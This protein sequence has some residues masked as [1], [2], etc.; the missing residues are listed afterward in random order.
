MN[1]VDLRLKLRHFFKKNGKIII[2]ILIIW[3]SIFFIN[4]ILKNRPVNLTPETT[5]EMH[6]SV[7]DVST[8][9]PSSLRKPIEDVIDEYVGYCNEGNY[10]KA[11]DMLSDDCKEYEFNNNVE[12]FMSHVISKMPVP[13]KYSIQDY[14]NFKC[15]NKT[16][17]VYQIKYIDDLLATGLTN[18]QYAYTSEKLTFYRDNNKLKM[19]AGDYMYHTDI[20]NISENEYLK[21]DIIDKL[22][23]YSTETYKVKIT[24]RSNY[25]VV[26]SDQQEVDEVILTLPNETRK[27]LE[28]DDI[29]LNPQQTIEV[30]FNFPKFADDGDESNSIVLSAI[31]VMEKYSGTQD[32][33]QEIIESEKANAI[34]K[35]SMEVKVTE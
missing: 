31:R 32:I 30:E 12:D 14:S 24:N 20:K 1:F 13:K 25:T 21:L 11:F 8:K 35:F 28:V 18:S 22:V 27:C 9:T 19:S 10:Q 23:R 17:Y 15:G 6:T 5:F 33:E 34:S 3:S 16:L 7:M 29:V 4:R 26:I 2:I